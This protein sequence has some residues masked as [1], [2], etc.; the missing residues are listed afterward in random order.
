[1]L[2]ASQNFHLICWWLG[3]WKVKLRWENRWIIFIYICCWFSRQV[4]SNSC[5]PVNWSLPGSSVHGVLQA[6]ILEWV[7]VPFSRGSAQ[8]RDWIMVSH[9]AGRFFTSWPSGKP[10]ICIYT[11]IGEGNSNP[12]QSSCLENPID[13]GTW[14]AKVHRVSESDTTEAT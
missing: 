4:I 13:R 5:N 2:Q 14:L 1:M 3:W 7:A 9:V 11:Y 10:F 8:P 6:R 12:L